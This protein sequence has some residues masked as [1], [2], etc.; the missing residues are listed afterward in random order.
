MDDDRT[1]HP[2]RLV[3]FLCVRA[4]HQRT[5][6][7]PVVSLQSGALLL[8]PSGETLGHVWRGAVGSPSPDDRR[9]RG[10]IAARGHVAAVPVHRVN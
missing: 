8:C 3:D 5:G 1:E 7:D 6:S 10:V 2:D 9:L 4:T